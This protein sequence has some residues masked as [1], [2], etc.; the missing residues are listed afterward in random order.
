MLCPS[1]QGHGWDTGTAIRCHPGCTTCY[2]FMHLVGSMWNPGKK[3]WNCVSASGEGNALQLLG[4]QAA[5]RGIPVK[6]SSPEQGFLLGPVYWWV[7]AKKTSSKG[8]ASESEQCWEM[9]WLITELMHC[10]EA[11]SQQSLAQGL[12]QNELQIIMIT[13][14]SYRGSR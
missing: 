8:C 2:C 13:F 4:G 7:S 10:N 1:Q 3:N 11:K 9:S 14:H 6:L 12:R 5:G